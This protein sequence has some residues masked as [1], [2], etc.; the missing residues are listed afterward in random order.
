MMDRTMGKGG[1]A[2]GEKEEMCGDCVGRINS[3]VQGTRP[4]AVSAFPQSISSA[5]TQL[6]TITFTY[7]TQLAYHD[8]TCRATRY[9]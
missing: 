1:G 2:R 6:N 7:L 4:N 5:R 3:H 8:I 9:G